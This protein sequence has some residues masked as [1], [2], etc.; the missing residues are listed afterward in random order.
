MEELEKKLKNLR[1]F[2]ASWR[3]QQCQQ[4]R[5]PPPTPGDWTIHQPKTTHGA[6]HICG[7]RWPSWTSVGGEALRSEG[8]RCPSVGKCQGGREEW[9]G[10]GATS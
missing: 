4:A 8:V 1:G 7:R 2:A 9:V 10:E 3:E 5:P 6:G